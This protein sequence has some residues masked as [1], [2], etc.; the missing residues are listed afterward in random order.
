MRILNGIIKKTFLGLGSA[1]GVRAFEM[2]VACD[3]RGKKSFLF[4]TAIDTPIVNMKFL[5]RIGTDIS[6]E[7]LTRVCDAVGVKSYEELKKKKIRFKIDTNNHIIDIGS[8]KKWAG[9]PELFKTVKT[10]IALYTP[11]KSYEK[12]K[13]E[14]EHEHIANTPFALEFYYQPEI[15]K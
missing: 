12:L 11:K 6:L 3:F 15:V 10:P 14:A 5:G 7:I 13:A 1:Q 8:E 4:N 2:E 9:F